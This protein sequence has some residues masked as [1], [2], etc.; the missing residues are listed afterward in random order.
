MTRQKHDRSVL[1]F[2]LGLT[3]AFGTAG[4]FISAQGLEKETIAGPTKELVDPNG[5]PAEYP[6]VIDNVKPGSGVDANGDGRI[7]TDSESTDFVDNDATNPAQSTRH[8]SGHGNFIVG[9][10]LLQQDISFSFHGIGINGSGR[11]AKGR[12]EFHDQTN[13]G[14]DL[15]VHG[16]VLCLTVDGNV[17]TLL[18]RVTRSNDFELP[19]D[20]IVIWMTQDN[21]EGTNADPDKLSRP[22]LT[23]SLP[24]DLCQFAKLK[25]TAVEISSGNIQVDED[26]TAS[27]APTS[28]EEKDPGDQS[29]ESFGVSGHGNFFDGGKSLTQDISFSFH[30]IGEGTDGKVISDVAKGEFE[31]HDQTPG[32]ADLT[33]HGD[34]VCATVSG[35]FA[36]LVGVV[37]RSNDKALPLLTLVSWQAVDNGEGEGDGLD[38]VSRLAPIGVNKTL[39]NPCAGKAPAANLRTVLNGNIQ[40]R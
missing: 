16:E 18:G 35:N 39:T 31:Y 34:V 40:V 4:V 26:E 25:F 6:V 8:A 21:G 13:A 20:G 28:L 3:L 30:A 15:T 36:R 9:G 2:A 22:S 27:D 7:C 17:A 38:Q 12:F 10:K 32:G 24:K 14:P 1:R 11:E 23:S 19:V 33:V 37:T 5:C 29:S